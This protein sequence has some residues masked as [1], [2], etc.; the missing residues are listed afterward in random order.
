MVNLRNQ[1]ELFEFYKSQL[2]DDCVSFWIRH[3]LD[4]ENGGYLTILDRQGVPYGSNKYVW[5][6][7]RG[8]YV[9]AKLYNVEENKQ[10]WLAAARLGVEFIEKFCMD[11]NGFA[12]YKVT[13]DGTPLYSRPWEIYAESFIVLAFAEYAKASGQERYLRSAEQIFWHIADRLNSDDLSRYSCIKTPQYR[14]HAPAMIMTNTAQEL[15]EINDDPRLQELIAR[16]VHEELYV[17]A[18]DEQRAMFERVNLDGSPA[19]SEPEGRSVTPGHCMESCWFCLREGAYQKDT[20]VIQRACEIIEWTMNIGW[21]SQFGGLFNFVDFMGKPPG[22]HDEDWG[23]DQDWDEKIF[24][25]HAEALYALLLA[26]KL[27]GEE[28]FFDW[29]EKLHHWSFKYFPDPV[30]GEWFGYL[31]R[32]GSVSQ[33]LKGCTKAFFHLPRALLNCML[34]LQQA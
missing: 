14:E 9:F 11:E 25:V 27:S 4:W 31:R 23:E 24:W 18:K 22:H 21:D 28:K 16:W 15:R 20:N 33:T 7:A 12:H 26:H 2:L 17:Y 10:D 29:Y 30:Y 3:S 19:L 13:R 5:S 8:A 34:L 6:Q 32:D 1:K